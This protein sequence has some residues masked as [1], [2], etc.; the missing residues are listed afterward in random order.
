MS[1]Q[2]NGNPDIWC[3][4]LYRMIR[5]HSQMPWFGIGEPYL[6]FHTLVYTIGIV[7]ENYELYHK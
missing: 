2:G 3:L 6:Q 5:K 1:L 7:V 4:V